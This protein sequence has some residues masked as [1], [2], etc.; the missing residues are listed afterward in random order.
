M[1]PLHI[2]MLSVSILGA[3]KY[4]DYPLSIEYIF[5]KNLKINEI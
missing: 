2:I 4:S 1:K 5:Y 3:S